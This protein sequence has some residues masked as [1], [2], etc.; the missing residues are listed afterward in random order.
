M[1]N[2]IYSIPYLTSVCY[3]S[4]PVWLCLFRCQCDLIIDGFCGVGGNAIQFAFTCER[5]IAIDIDPH[6]IQLARQNAAVY[7]VEDRIEFIVGDFFQ[8]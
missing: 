1:Y 3:F 7:G 8:V 6:K 2:C 5:V 4:S